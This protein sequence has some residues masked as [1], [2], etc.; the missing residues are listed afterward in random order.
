MIVIVV[1]FTPHIVMLDIFYL[2]IVAHD[3]FMKGLYIT[4]DGKLMNVL[5]VEL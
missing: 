5:S 2:Y 4:V 1:F 3:W